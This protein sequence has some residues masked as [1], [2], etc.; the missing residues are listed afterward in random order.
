MSRSGSAPAEYPARD[1]QEVLRENSASGIASASIIRLGEAKRVNVT[2]AGISEDMPAEA[3]TPAKL[4]VSLPPAT[5][6][7]PKLLIGARK[8]Y[9]TTSIIPRRRTRTAGTQRTVSELQ[10]AQSEDRSAQR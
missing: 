3:G 10:P 6:P 5:I 8:P 7:A 2:N 9:A 1:V 4:A